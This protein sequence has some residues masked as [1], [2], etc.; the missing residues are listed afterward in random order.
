M[1]ELKRLWQ[2][3]MNK[4]LQNYS[5]IFNQKLDIFNHIQGWCNQEQFMTLEYIFSYL[6]SKK[7]SGDIIELGVYTGKCSGILNNHIS[8]NEKLKLVDMNFQYD[9]V[10]NNIGKLSNNVNNVEIYNQMTW[11]ID[12]FPK[13]SAKFIHIDAGHSY[14][15]CWNDLEM[16]LPLL[17]KNRNHCG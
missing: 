7:I 8:G 12:S 15:N 9:V 4:N 3:N 13:D 1:V 16:S 11:C 2:F 10:M 14:D 5:D 6:D 17:K